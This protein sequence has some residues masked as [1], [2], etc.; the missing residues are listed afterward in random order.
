MTV[1][2]GLRRPE[3]ATANFLD[4]SLILID[5]PKSH[6]RSLG[7]VS[8]NRK[9]QEQEIFSTP[10]PLLDGAVVPNYNIAQFR[11]MSTVRNR[12]DEAI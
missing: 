4:V 5:P 1:G 8:R 12:R 9:L 3:E 10:I 7:Q 11:K 2:L 6:G